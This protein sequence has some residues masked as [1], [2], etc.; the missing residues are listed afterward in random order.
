MSDIRSGLGSVLHVLGAELAVAHTLGR[1]AIWRANQTMWVN[2]EFCGAET[3]YLC[4]FERLTSC[5]LPTPDALRRAVKLPSKDLTLNKTS[6][7]SA[8]VVTKWKG[9]LDRT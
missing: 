6:W 4:Y 5:P 9:S 3:S 2:G 7:I 1:I 8:N